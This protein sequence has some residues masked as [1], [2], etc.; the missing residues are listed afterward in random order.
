[1]IYATS[2]VNRALL[3]LFS[4]FKMLEIAGLEWWLVMFD[5]EIYWDDS[6]THWRITIC[7]S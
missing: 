1:M 4:F 7:R 3:R 2:S 5:M 6:G